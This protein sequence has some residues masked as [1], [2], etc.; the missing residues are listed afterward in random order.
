M[1][2]RDVTICNMKH[3]ECG[4][5]SAVQ[6]VDIVLI[7]DLHYGRKLQSFAGIIE[8]FKLENYPPYRHA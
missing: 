7:A 5:H 4:T 6:T 3:T 2:G 8:Y 1:P